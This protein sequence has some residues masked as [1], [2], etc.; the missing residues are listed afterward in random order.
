MRFLIDN[1]L[2]PLLADAL[3]AVQHDAVHVRDYGM[4]KAGDP[5]IFARAAAEDRIILSADTDFGTLLAQRH[6][7]KPSVILFRRGT[8]RRP[9][10][11]LRLLLAHLAMLEDALDRGSIVV[12]GD[13]RIRVRALPII[14]V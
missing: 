1:P 11:Q 10:D 2:S 12:F 14:P 4:A 8:D 7:S 13:A 9:D 5:E 6:E 3:R